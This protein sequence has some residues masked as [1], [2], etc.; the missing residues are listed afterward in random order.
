MG[1]NSDFVFEAYELDQPPQAVVRVPPV[2]PYKAREQGIEGVVQVKLLINQDGS[3][4]HLEI[5]D[6]RPEGLFEEA[7]RNAVPQWKFSPG[8]IDGQT[9]TAWVVT[10]VRFTLD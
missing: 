2:Y 5:L 9:V 3:V 4:G 10:Y 7:V 8:K 1:D 6:A